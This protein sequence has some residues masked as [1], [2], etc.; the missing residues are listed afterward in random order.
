MDM[1]V[2]VAKMRADLENGILRRDAA[3]VS[4]QHTLVMEVIRLGATVDL[5]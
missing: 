1:L 3:V 5:Q 2:G 4:C